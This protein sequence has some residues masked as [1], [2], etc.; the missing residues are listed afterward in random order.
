MFPQLNSLTALLPLLAVLLATDSHAAHNGHGSLARRHQLHNR[1]S[2]REIAPVVVSSL[3]KRAG[4]PSRQRRSCLAK[5]SSSLVA[6]TQSATKTTVKATS[7]KAASSTKGASSGN[8]AAVGGS[9]K[10]AN[11]PSQTQ[12]GAAPAAT[13]TSAADPFLMALSKSYNNRNNPLYTQTHVGQMT[14]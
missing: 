1:L 11:W 9:G 8:N 6:S 2:Y 4:K 7:T 3:E 14:Y 13:R 12:A 10:P 5:P